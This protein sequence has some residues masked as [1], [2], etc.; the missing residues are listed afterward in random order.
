MKEKLI[1]QKENLEQLKAID[2]RIKAM[3]AKFN[4]DIQELKEELEYEY[5]K[6]EIEKRKLEI[7]KEV[8]DTYAETKDKTAIGGLKVQETTIYN[9]DSKDALNYAKNHDLFLM[10]DKKS[11]EKY[12]KSTKEKIDFV[13]VNN[14]LRV[15]W[16]KEIK[17]ED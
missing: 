5:L 15:T 8:L 1:E 2:D 3:K 17:L 13:T 10:L 9:Y 16:P 11:F 6:G 7:E 12:I 4:D 14:G